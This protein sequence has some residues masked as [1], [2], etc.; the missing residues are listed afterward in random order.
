[1]KTIAY[2][3]GFAVLGV[4]SIFVL[5]IVNAF[6]RETAQHLQTLLP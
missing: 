6:I 2:T 1:M 3:V 5:L 4:A